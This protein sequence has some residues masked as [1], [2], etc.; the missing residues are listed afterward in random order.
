LIWFYLLIEEGEL[1]SWG[2]GL[3]GRLGHG[4]DTEQLLPKKIEFFSKIKQKVVKIFSG[5]GHNFA[6]TGTLFLGLDVTFLSLYKHLAHD[7]TLH[8]HPAQILI[9]YLS[10]L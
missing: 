1:Y 6:I 8:T 5:G 4:D 3:N 10:I 2:S 7:N 9:L